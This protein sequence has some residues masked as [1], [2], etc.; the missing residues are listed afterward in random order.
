MVTGVSGVDPVNTG[1]LLPVTLGGAFSSQVSVPVFL[2]LKD[3]RRCNLAAQS[4]V[5]Q[6]PFWPHPWHAEI[7]RPGTEPAPQQGQ[8]QVL[9]PA[10]PQETPFHLS[11][12]G[13]L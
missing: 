11:L 3:L 13:V 10:E 12:L 9:N 8:G 4:L 6:P 7:P 5:P 1:S 2:S